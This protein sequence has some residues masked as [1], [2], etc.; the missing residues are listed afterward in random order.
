MVDPTPS[1]PLS[2]QYVSR[3]AQALGVL[4]HETRLQA[5]LLLAVLGETHVS[6]LVAALD[7]TQSNLSHHLR[8]LRD[9]GLVTD[10]RDGK[11]VLYSLDVD[12]WRDL[13]DGFFDSLLGGEDAV[14]LQE[15]R[16]ERLRRSV[17]GDG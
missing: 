14:T 6:A 1:G 16:I 5:V 12:T 17:P 13:A 3:S 7:I 4:S 9:A 11:Y 10:R 8:I 2:P 15:F